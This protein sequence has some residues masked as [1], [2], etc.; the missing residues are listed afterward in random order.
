MCFVATIARV[1]TQSS[2]YFVPNYCHPWTGAASKETAIKVSRNPIE[3]TSWRAQPT[4]DS[5]HGLSRR[6]QKLLLSENSTTPIEIHLIAFTCCSRSRRS[7]QGVIEVDSRKKERLEFFTN[8]SHGSV[9]A[10]LKNK[11][12]PAKTLAVRV[13]KV[14]P[15]GLIQWERRRITKQNKQHHARH[16]KPI[17]QGKR[18]GQ[19]LNI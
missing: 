12:T 1:C 9:E 10:V 14:V 3:K 17:S 7:W 16:E 15:I 19:P 2:E 6:T 13:R 8:N 5:R 18:Q 11:I 4:Q